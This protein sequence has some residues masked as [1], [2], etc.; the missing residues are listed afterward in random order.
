MDLLQ[1]FRGNIKDTQR[2]YNYYIK[3]YQGCG[4]GAGGYPGALGPGVRRVGVM[5][6]GAAAV[7]PANPWAPL[8]HI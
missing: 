3:V 2:E 8:A 4:S 7:G 6:G 1:A 5:R